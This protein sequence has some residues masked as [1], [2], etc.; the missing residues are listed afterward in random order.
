VQTPGTV[1]TKRM[2]LAT[3]GT[4]VPH[5]ASRSFAIHGDDSRAL[6]LCSTWDLACDWRCRCAGTVVSRISP[7]KGPKGNVGAR[8]HRQRTMRRS[9]PMHLPHRVP[10]CA[11]RLCNGAG[12]QKSECRRSTCHVHWSRPAQCQHH[13]QAG[14]QAGHRGTVT[15]PPKAF[16]HGAT[17][18]AMRLVGVIGKQP[19]RATCLINVTRPR[20][21][22]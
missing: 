18:C 14:H 9:A 1:T 16:C 8:G 21:A 4:I 15:R 12:L 6:G 3:M 17:R 13:H 11:G 5:G 22:Q 10:S 20:T 19:L 2:C 7:A